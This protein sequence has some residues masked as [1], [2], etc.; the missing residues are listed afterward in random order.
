MKKRIKLHR[1]TL[2]SLD[3]GVLIKVGGGISGELPATQCPGASCTYCNHT[4]CNTCIC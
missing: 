1:E 4:H 2:R 3:T